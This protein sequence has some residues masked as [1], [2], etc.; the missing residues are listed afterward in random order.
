MP[1]NESCVYISA[2]VTQKKYQPHIKVFIIQSSAPSQQYRKT[3]NLTL[4]NIS[5]TPIS[6]IAVDYVGF[7][8]FLTNKSISGV[9]YREKIFLDKAADLKDHIMYKAYEENH[10]GEDITP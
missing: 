2:S 8:G 1:S 7:C 9:E 10:S 5:S 3:V 6:Q 4:E